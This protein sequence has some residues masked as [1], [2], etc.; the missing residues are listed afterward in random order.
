MSA[1]G[2]WL[3]A[4]VALVL[5]SLL[6]AEAGAVYECGGQQD[7]CQCGASNPYPCCDNGGN[8]TWWAWHSACCN[9]SYGLPGWG[10]ANTWAGNANAHPDFQVVGNPVVGS[11]AAR[12]AGTYGHVAWVTDVNGGTIIVT[13]EN[14]CT[15]CNWGMRSWTYNASYFDAGF[16]VPV[17]QCQCSNGD[18]QDQGCGNCG[19]RSRSCGG[20]CMWGAWSS[21]SGEGACS[22]GQTETTDCGDCGQ[23]SRSC[24]GDCQWSGW[25]ACEG[26]DPGGGTLACDSGLPGA[27]ADGIERCLAGTLTCE[28]NAAGAAEICDGVDNDCDGSID[29]GA[30]G[31]GGSS[32]TGGHSAGAG[33]PTGPGHGAGGAGGGNALGGGLS[34]DGDDLIEGY[35]A[36]RVG[37]RPS[38]RGW[39]ALFTALALAWAARRRRN[40]GGPRCRRVREEHA[41]GTHPPAGGW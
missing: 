22:D 3:A 25:S 15:G 13:E 40:E 4:V 36:C 17:S 20:D 41:K 5:L 9:W 30:C 26:D 10:N 19:Q 23:Q 1:P 38:R 21:C 11:I 6:P 2:R 28:P 18:T 31:A 37:P 34:A 33:T 32:A 7:T 29:E 24:G 16:I 12:N 8:C 27:C 39:P 35:C 14:C